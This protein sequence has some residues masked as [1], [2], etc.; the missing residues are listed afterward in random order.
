MNS[1]GRQPTGKRQKPFDPAGVARFS[2]SPL[3]V[4]THGYPCL[5]ASRPE[6]QWQSQ[7]AVHG[8]QSLRAA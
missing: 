1:L 8:D 3:W 5:A 2:A 7:A 6:I 4:N